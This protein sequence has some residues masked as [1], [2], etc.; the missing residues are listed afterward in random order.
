[1][2]CY[3]SP[4]LKSQ[5]TRHKPLTTFFQWNEREMKRLE[6]LSWYLF[7]M[8]SLILELCFYC[9][10]NLNSSLLRTLTILFNFVSNLHQSLL[11]HFHLWTFQWKSI[12]VREFC[13][14]KEARIEKKE[15]RKSKH[16]RNLCQ[17]P[18]RLRLVDT[19]IAINHQIG[20]QN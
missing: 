7:K 17:T 10:K 16:T 3:I 6:C 14:R 19:K 11:S 1:M 20:Q 9:L 2:I 15:K 8:F 18:F 4:T 5:T 12:L 13:R